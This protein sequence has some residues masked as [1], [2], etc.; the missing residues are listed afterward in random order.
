MI[1]L[2]PKH[3]IKGEFTSILIDQLC[4]QLGGCTCLFDY[5]YESD[6][7]PLTA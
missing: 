2:S 5:V 7:K 3:K 1:H 6:A 4:L